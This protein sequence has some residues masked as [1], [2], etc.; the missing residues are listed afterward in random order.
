MF[1]ILT[2]SHNERGIWLLGSYEGGTQ[3]WKLEKAPYRTVDPSHT[4]NFSTL[5]QSESQSS[6]KILG[7]EMWGERMKKEDILDPFLVI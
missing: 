4:E 1:Q 5:A 3:F 7:T 6:S 2:K